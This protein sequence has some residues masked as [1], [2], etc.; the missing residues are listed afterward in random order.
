MHR[1]PTALF[2]QKGNGV[3]GT[4]AA[5]CCDDACSAFTC[6]SGEHLKSNA[7]EIAG[8][9]AG[10]CCNTDVTGKCSGN[11]DSSEDVTCGANKMLRSNS[12]TIT[13]SNV[14]TCCEDTI[15]GM[16]DG[17]TDAAEDVTCGALVLWHMSSVQD[18]SLS[19]PGTC[20]FS[21]HCIATRCS[22][23]ALSSVVQFGMPRPWPHRAS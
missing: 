8:D 5:A 3:S 11:T 18:N 4:D 6:P 10:D 14:A 7:A 19:T 20:T 1:Q 22:Q 16:C 17:N 9:S 21:V 23:V 12:N 2:S 15:T 13:G